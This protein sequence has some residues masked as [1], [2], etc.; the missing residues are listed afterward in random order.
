MKIVMVGAG[1]CPACNNYKP[2][3][4][5]VKQA[6]GFQHPDIEWAYWNAD[7]V[8]VSPYG[9][10]TIPVTMALDENDVI[11]DKVVGNIEEYALAQFVVNAKKTAQT[12]EEDIS[13]EF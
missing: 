3:F 13:I 7:T 4:D 8:D 12:V 1:W 10:T 5:G 9:I 2:T 11:I 6:L